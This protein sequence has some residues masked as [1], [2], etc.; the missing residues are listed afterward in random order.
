MNPQLFNKHPI[1]DYSKIDYSAL[2]NNK[3][4]AYLDKI[5]RFIL[6]R[7]FR[8]SAVSNRIIDIGGGFGRL[9]D[10]YGNSFKKIIL[11]DYSDIQLRD[12]AKRLKSDP[13]IAFVRGDIFHLPFKNDVFDT[14]LMIRVLHHIDK[15]KTVFEEIKNILINQGNFCFTFYN[16]LDFR[17]RIKS[18][19]KNRAES[20]AKSEH[21]SIPTDKFLYLSHPGFIFRLLN[22][23]GYEVRDRFGIGLFTGRFLALNWLFLP[24]DILFCKFLGLLN[25][26]FEMLL[27][28]RLKK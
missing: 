15:P 5:E 1:P 9:V 6:K 24:V 28:A 20:V 13:R 12:A 17:Q 11:F 3:K 18:I 27:C 10:T 8:H 22:D 19:L 26:T 7:V 16:S 4:R 21:K 14:V 2:W 25:L 23:S